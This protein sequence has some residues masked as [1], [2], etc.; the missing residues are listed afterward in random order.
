[1]AGFSSRGPNSIN[2]IK[3]DVGGPGV[4]ILAA[5]ANGQAPAPEYQFLSGTSMSSPHRKSA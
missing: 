1:M 4:S 2:V 5:E 3:P